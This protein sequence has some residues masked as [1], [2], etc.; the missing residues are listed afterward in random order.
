MTNFEFTMRFKLPADAQA[1]EAYLDALFK[2]GC[3]DAMIGTGRPGY[4]T[5]DFDRTAA[6]LEDATISARKDVEA[7]IPGADLIDIDVDEVFAD[8]DRKRDD[9]SLTASIANRKRIDDM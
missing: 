5:L 6:T 3:D 4:I 9:G 7:A 8:L 1:P 2:A